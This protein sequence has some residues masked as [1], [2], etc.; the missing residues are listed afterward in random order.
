M[1][2]PS[3]HWSDEEDN[4]LRVFYPRHG[5]G[6]EGWPEVL[7][8]RSRHAIYKRAKRIGLSQGFSSFGPYP[9]ERRRRTSKK[10]KPTE[11][12]NRP[13]KT[14]VPR[15]CTREDALVLEALEQGKT[16][17]QIDAERHWYPGTTVRVMRAIWER[18]ND[19]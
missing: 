17:T 2:R 11:R 8:D 6:W 15:G 19:G 5:G 16:P 18:Q 12:P 14:A 7:P 13:A 10:E 3:T 4:A 1:S 9:P